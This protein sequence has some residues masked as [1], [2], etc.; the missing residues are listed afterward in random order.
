MLGENSVKKFSAISECLNGLERFS[1]SCFES[2]LLF[3]FFKIL[4]FFMQL[5]LCLLE[6]SDLADIILKSTPARVLI[7]L[8]YSNL[9]YTNVSR[10]IMKSRS[11]V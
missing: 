7:I 10:N 5:T 8:I 1:F 9:I 6:F 11:R 2:A 4:A 3:H